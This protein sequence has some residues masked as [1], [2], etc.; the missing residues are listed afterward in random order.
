ML[1]G[2]ASLIFVLQQG[3]ALLKGSYQALI[4][5]SSYEKY[6]ETYRPAYVL[7]KVH[8]EDSKVLNRT[9]QRIQYETGFYEIHDACTSRIIFSL[10]FLTS[11]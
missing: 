4:G 10:N 5:K 6:Q 1:D 7:N 8:N 2:I 11:C 3:S 9:D